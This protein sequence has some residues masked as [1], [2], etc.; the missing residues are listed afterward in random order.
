M[1]LSHSIVSMKITTVLSRLK[2]HP[3]NVCV[4][5]TVN[6]HGEPEAATMFYMLNKDNK[7]ILCTHLFTHKYNNILTNKHVYL[8]F[9]SA[10]EGINVQCSGRA[11]IIRAGE[12]FRT[13]GELY[14]HS[15]SPFHHYR[16]DDICFIEITL[17]KLTVTDYNK[18]KAKV[19]VFDKL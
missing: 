7:F 17:T 9:G 10:L 5:A 19:F 6:E 14:F 18:G 11:R 16:Y 12:E 1:A 13:M 3:F 2:K 8:V 15:K 4:L